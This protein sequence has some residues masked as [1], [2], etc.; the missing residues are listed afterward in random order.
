MVFKTQV[1]SLYEDDGRRREA[2]EIRVIILEAQVSAR[3]ADAEASLVPPSATAFVPGHIFW[4]LLGIARSEE[5]RA[6]ALRTGPAGLRWAKPAD[7]VQPR[8]RASGCRLMAAAV[9]VDRWTCRFH[10]RRTICC[11]GDGAV[12]PRC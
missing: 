1:E 3:A 9:R 4:P 12:S 2:E 8:F 6:L 10:N 5:Q 11:A 7:K